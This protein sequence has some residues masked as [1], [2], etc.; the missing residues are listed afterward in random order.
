MI[1]FN[2]R[3][4]LEVSERYLQKPQYLTFADRDFLML[5]P[6]RVDYHFKL[7]ENIYVHAIQDIKDYYFDEGY[8]KVSK[9]GEYV[10]YIGDIMSFYP[11]DYAVRKYTNT[12]S[13]LVF[14]YMFDY[15]GELNLRKKQI[16]DNAMSIDGAW[17]A[18]TGDELCYLFVCNSLRKAYTKALKDEDSE[19]IKVLKNMVRLWTN[20]ARTG[21]PTP[22]GNDFNWHP[23]SHQKKECLVISDEL[24]MVERLYDDTVNFWDDWM[25]K[26]GALAVNGVVQDVKDEL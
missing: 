19:D 17:G 18:T 24:T 7:N 26:Y 10:T 8:I 3:E 11:T 4:G 2:S 20:F 6:I 23:A 22:P 21:N 15:S 13:S 9:P 12:S 25:A 1:G 16:L 5:F 14:Y